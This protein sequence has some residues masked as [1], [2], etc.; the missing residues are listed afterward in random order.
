[1]LAAG[2]SWFDYPLWGNIPSPF[3]PTDIIA[4]LKVVGNPTPVILNVSHHGD[5]TTD[6]M[7][8]PKQQR[9]IDAL[10]NSA[11][12]LDKGQPDAIL[13]SGGGNDI[14]GDQFCI[15]LNY[16]TGG[17]ATTGLNKNRFQKV[18]GGVEASYLDLF[19]FR[20]RYARSVSIYGHC[21]DL[22]IPNGVPA[23]PF[24]GPWLKPSLDFCGW[25]L[26]DG[27]AIVA[28]ALTEFKKKLS[29]LTA[30][31]SFY[32]VDTQ[33]TLTKADW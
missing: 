25:D 12:W 31:N 26:N 11:N 16:N 15:S 3:F 29:T 20:D 23:G 28:E 6:E 22:A 30:P 24:A 14:A 27:T 8:W 9:M 18:L 7:S 4:Q 2:G 10:Q 5:A 32:L 17:G 33:K 1:M 13:F 21:Y 19:A